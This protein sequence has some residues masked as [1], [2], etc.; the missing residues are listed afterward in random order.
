MITRQ[1]E[2][3]EQGAILRRNAFHSGFTARDD[4]DVAGDDE[5]YIDVMAEEWCLKVAFKNSI[6]Q[7][8]VVHT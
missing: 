6:Q 3:E 4:D 2:K 7:I 1:D 8:N 5:R